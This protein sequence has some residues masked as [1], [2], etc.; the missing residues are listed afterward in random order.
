MLTLVNQSTGRGAADAIVPLYIKRA[1]HAPSVPAEDRLHMLYLFGD[2]LR[3]AEVQSNG[4]QADVW[5]DLSGA[6]KT[7]GNGFTQLTHLGLGLVAA[8]RQEDGATPVFD[9]REDNTA[10][11][12]DLLVTNL[13]T[14]MAAGFDTLLLCRPGRTFLLAY[15]RSSGRTDTTVWSNDTGW[16]PVHTEMVPLPLGATALAYL[17]NTAVN[18]QPGSGYLATLVGGDLHIFQA[19]I[20]NVLGAEFVSITPY[21]TLRGWAPAD[22]QLL[23]FANQP[24]EVFLFTYERSTGRVR[25]DRFDG[26]P[27]FVWGDTWSPDSVIASVRDRI[28]RYGRSDGTLDHY[29]V[30]APL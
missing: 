5:D 13:S 17:H 27:S 3:L 20:N 25:M 18:A 21:R 23:A 12:T 29:K 7:L 9:A 11:L 10:S 22:S 19:S 1:W 24:N 30:T 14:T 15:D 28:V 26:L 8:Y 4:Y 16:A 6:T 2:T